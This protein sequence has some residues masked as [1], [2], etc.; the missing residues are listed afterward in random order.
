MDFIINTYDC[1]GSAGYNFFPG[2]KITKNTIDK[3]SQIKN[4][5]DGFM[6]FSLD[7]YDSFENFGM[8]ILNDKKGSLKFYNGA[9]FSNEYTKPQF[10]SN[11][12]SLQGVSFQKQT[13]AFSVGV[14]WFSILQYRAMLN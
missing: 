14:Y 13:I 12:G 3:R 11:G 1:P 6:A 4:Q 8:F 10:D 2:L 7:G 9:P 5:L